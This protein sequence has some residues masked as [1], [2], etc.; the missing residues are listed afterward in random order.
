MEQARQFCVIGYP[1]GHTMSPPIHKRLFALSGDSRAQYGVRE[2]PPEAL[3]SEAE[4]LLKTMTGF[5]V[6]IP[7][8]LGIMDS[9]THLDE[10]ARRYGAVNVV[11]CRTKT[12]YNTDVVGFTR[13][14]QGIGGSLKG[15]VLLLG[16][17]GAG[18][19]MAIETAFSGGGLTM[20]VRE[21]DLPAARA[22]QAEIGE[23]VPGAAVDVTT[24]DNICGEF[25]LLCNATPVGMYPHDDA[26]PVGEDVI[27]QCGCVF[28][29][30]YNPHE[31]VLIKTAHRLGKQAAGGMA[32]L[33]WQAVAAHEIWDNASYS[34]ADIQALIQEMGERVQ[35]DF[36]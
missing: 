8:K 36:R 10:T 34:P 17:G 32:M 20:A 13:A 21:S 9:L 18:R 27:A 7:H 24:L 6:T 11:D 3:K 16:C 23:K 1:L 4:L 15:R 5:N 22:L 19:M 28:D 29:A 2:I 26:C 25:D 30:V 35:A 12:G 31:T 14:V 33:V